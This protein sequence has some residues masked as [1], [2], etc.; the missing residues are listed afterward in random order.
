MDANYKSKLLASA[1]TA[2]LLMSGLVL[3]T[4]AQAGPADDLEINDVVETLGSPPPRVN[5]PYD[6]E[7]TWENEG[8]TDYD[9]T[10][11]LYDDCDMSS[12]E[13]EDMSPVANTS[14]VYCCK[15][16]HVCSC[17]A[18]HVSCCNTMDI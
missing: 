13:A 17:N 6:L 14:H 12:V 18:T 3:L 2:V 16:G 7:I 4:G 9:A 1:V 11:R 8:S 10:V 5:I 15:T